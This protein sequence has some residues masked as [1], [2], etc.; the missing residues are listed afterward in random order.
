MLKCYKTV[1]LNCNEYLTSMVSSSIVKYRQI[2]QKMYIRLYFNLNI[3]LQSH[4]IAAPEGFDQVSNYLPDQNLPPG[5]PKCQNGGGESSGNWTS[6]C[7]WCWLYKWPLVF[8]GQRFVPSLDVPLYQCRLCF[9][10]GK[11]NLID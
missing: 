3:L 1:I 6:V 11:N 8:K 10:K 2:T 5:V 9:E 4:W 7:H